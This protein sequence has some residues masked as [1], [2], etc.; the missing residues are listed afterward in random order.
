[1]HLLAGLLGDG[2]RGFPPSALWCLRPGITR[3]DIGAHCLAAIVF[4]LID[5]KKARPG[6]HEKRDAHRG[7]ETEKR[8][9]LSALRRTLKRGLPKVWHC[10]VHGDEPSAL[11]P[12]FPLILHQAAR[13]SKKERAQE[14]LLYW[15]AYNSFKKWHFPNDFPKCI[16]SSLK[17]TVQSGQVKWGAEGLGDPLPGR[18]R[19]TSASISESLPSNNR[20]LTL[21]PI[22]LERSRI[23]KELSHEGF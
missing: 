5:S 3:P 21:S 22:A 23:Q 2:G 1:M 7:L 18:A 9:Q 11:P 16:V 14:G 19:S 15:K 4:P 6:N 13:E 10:R 12:L 17:S 20:E 8:R